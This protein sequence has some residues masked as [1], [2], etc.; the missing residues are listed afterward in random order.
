M[1]SNRK[2]AVAGMFYPAGK[3]ELAKMISQLLAEAKTDEK[4]P[5]GIIVPH[6]GYAYSG[7]TAAFAYN[8]LLNI[9]KERQIRNIIILGPAHNVYFNEIFQSNSNSWETPIGKIELGKIREI[10]ESEKAHAGE[11]SIEVQIPFVQKIL[12]D[13]KKKIPITPIIVGEITKEQAKKYADMFSRQENCFFI[14][15][16][17]L[18]HFML[19]EDAEKTDFDTIKKITALDYKDIDACGKYPLMI[20]IELAKIKN[21]KFK[22]LKY[23]SSAETSGDESSVVGYASFVF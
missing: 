3:K 11:H 14:V 7:K 22:L 12:E 1:T 20:I 16:T 21:W 8:S 6:A 18:S 17:D 2:P 10:K 23:S 9:L 13:A 15:S 19:K 4:A 5:N